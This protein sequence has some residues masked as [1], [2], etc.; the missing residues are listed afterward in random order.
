M[1][2]LFILA[3]A[4]IVALAACTKTEVVYTEAPAEIGFKQI[5]D[6]MTKAVPDGTQLPATMG[7]YAYKGSDA[8]FTNISYS[9]KTTYWGATDDN[10]KAYWPLDNSTLTFTVY[11]PHN[12]N[13]TFVSD[14]LTI[15][16][17]TNATDVLYGKTQPTG[18][19][20]ANATTPVD[21][22]L[23]HAFAQVLVVFKT[24]ANVE[25]NSVTFNNVVQ[26]GTCKVTYPGATV[27]WDALT[28]AAPVALLAADV[29]L[30]SDAEYPFLAVPATLTNQELTFE[31]TLSG[32]PKQSHT[33]TTAELTTAKWVEGKR[34]VYN[35]AIGAAE[36]QFNP[37]VEAWDENVDADP[38]DDSFDFS[39]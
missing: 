20:T 30:T 17:V 2:R 1:K 15:P 6:V 13:A 12:A 29:E 21:V 25:L 28:T 3:S 7:V 18:N 36:I 19:K 34:Y 22:T 24:A 11:A 32:S 4:A 10:E 27:A 8:Y 14:V 31:Y 33:I 39:I 16:N 35:I 37:T 38:E 23:G 26:G 5:T 9:D